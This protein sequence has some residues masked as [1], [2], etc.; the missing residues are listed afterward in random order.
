MNVFNKVTLQSLKK[1]KTRTIVTIIGIILS[2]AMICAVTTFASSIYD[3]ALRVAIWG[4]GSW[5]GSEV[6]TSYETYQKIEDA[7][8]VKD[9]VYLQQLGY[10]YAK[11]CA[12][13]YKPYIY[14]VGA[15]E[16]VD[17]MLPIH[18]TQG[19]YPNSSDEILIPNHLAT[20]GGI[21]YKLGDTI[22]LELGDRMLDGYK[23][24]QNNPAYVY[25]NGNEVLNDESIEVR[26]NRTFTVVGFYDR[27]TYRIEPNSAPG[28][29]AI[30]VADTSALSEYS[31][32]VYFRMDNAKDVFDFMD[33]YDLS[34]DRNTDVLMYQ[35][36]TQYDS[37]SVM[38]ISLASIVIALIMFGSI[39]LIY[40]AFSISVSERTKQF[41]LLSSLGA[42]KKQ[43]RKM[44]LFE[45]LTVAGIGIPVGGIAGI[46]GIGVTLAVIGNKF[47]SLLGY[48]DISM[49]L[50]V[51]WEAVIIAVVVALVTVLLSA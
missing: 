19:E 44:V 49:R 17:E 6:N 40:N 34:G 1:N 21:R 41:G 15:S 16:G 50:C 7:N 13:E 38:V 2:A 11:D 29:T 26:E 14:V 8:E 31:Y 4:D 32:E 47:S 30:T 20:N 35:G 23:M 39:A 24:N 42:T 43:L 48:S 22:S 37:F 27:L 5:H 3:Y 46:A 51:S 45:A 18:I 25:K 36:A 28:Y 9:T 12:N 10:A 33:E